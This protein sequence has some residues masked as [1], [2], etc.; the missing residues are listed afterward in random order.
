[1]RI[2]TSLVVGLLML[3]AGCSNEPQEKAVTLLN[4]EA[5]DSD[6]LERVRAFAERELH[7]PARAVE[8]SKL[9]GKA[10]FQSLE[11]AALRVKSNA[12]AT[13]IVLA[14]FN[15]GHSI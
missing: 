9:A 7:V 1:M 8:N 3:S 12:D 2:I 14:G 13:L 11:K 15:G 5:V 6:L 4:A 10:N